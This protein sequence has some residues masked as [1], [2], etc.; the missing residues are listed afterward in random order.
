MRNNEFKHWKKASTTDVQHK[1][2]VVPLWFYQEPLG[3]QHVK[4]QP[5]QH[6]NIMC[7]VPW[8][9]S[10]QREVGG[11][12]QTA[13]MRDMREGVCV[14][15]STADQLQSELW[16]Q[17]GV[18]ITRVTSNMKYRADRIKALGNGQVPAVAATAWRLL[19]A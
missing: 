18:E 14:S 10:R 6:R 13:R 19:T 8:K 1:G 15:E 7:A 9:D 3:Q 4:Q 2:A 16:E 12:Q 5:E 17:N 11:P